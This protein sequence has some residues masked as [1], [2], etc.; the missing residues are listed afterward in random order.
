MHGNKVDILFVKVF[1]QSYWVMF[2]RN[3]SERHEAV[4]SVYIYMDKDTSHCPS[5]LLPFQFKKKEGFW[6]AWP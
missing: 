6:G 1:L 2:L 4:E 3:M 5:V